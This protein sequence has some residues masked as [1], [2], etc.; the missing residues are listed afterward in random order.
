MLIKKKKGQIGDAIT[1]MIATIVII[2]LLLFFIFGASLLASTKKIGA[3]RE[4]LT[5]KQT[6]EGDDLLLRKSLYTYYSIK[7][8]NSKKQVF[9]GLKEMDKRGEFKLSLNKIDRKSVV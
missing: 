5:S 8:E 4:S 6:F 3:F 2:V 9:D 1:W 7:S